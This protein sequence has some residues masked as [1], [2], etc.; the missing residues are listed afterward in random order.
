MGCFFLYCFIRPKTG[1]LLREP[2]SSESVGEGGFDEPLSGGVKI[3]VLRSSSFIWIGWKVF[4][5][6]DESSLKRAAEAAAAAVATLMF[7]MGDGLLAMYAAEE[8]ELLRCKIG[9]GEKSWEVLSG[10]VDMD[11][12]GCF[13]RV[14]TCVMESSNTK[15]SPKPPGEVGGVSLNG[16]G[17]MSMT[18]EEGDESMLDIDTERPPELEGAA[19]RFSSSLWIK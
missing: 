8:T 11:I 1:N 19:N 9:L 17:A 16:D 6:R 15:T 10:I 13:G 4:T 14:G 7:M 18:G 5:S 2:P 3:V 12:V